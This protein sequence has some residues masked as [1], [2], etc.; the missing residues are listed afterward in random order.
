MTTCRWCNTEIAYNREVDAYVSMGSGP[1]CTPRGR[2]AVCERWYYPAMFGID[3]L[4]MPDH[5]C[6][7]A[8]Q[9]SIIHL[10]VGPNEGKI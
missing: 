10:P 9:R 1:V 5:D 7:C 2:D 3:P 6:A 8:C 4:S